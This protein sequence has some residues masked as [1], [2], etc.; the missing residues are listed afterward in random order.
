MWI[1]VD[2]NVFLDLL[3][4][5]GHFADEASLFFTNCYKNNHR[6]LLTSISIRDIG[7]IAHQVFHN[8]KDAKKI[9][10]SAY[11]LCTKVI[12]IT[13]DDAIESLYSDMKD[14]EDSLIVE[15]AKREMAD[16]IVT[17]NRKDFANANFPVT[18]PKDF[19]EATKFLQNK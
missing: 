7:Y 18:T 16:L 6:V 2:T 12:S 10:M 11:Q 3:L 19:N 5:R 14:Y 9:Q 15:A 8:E 17:N 1:V 4:D 13:N